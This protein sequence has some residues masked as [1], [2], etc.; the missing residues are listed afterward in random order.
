MWGRPVEFEKRRVR[1]VDAFWNCGALDS[2]EASGV[3]VKVPLR[4]MPLPWAG[5]VL[6]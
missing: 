1:E 3:G 6:R 4:R 5:R 2:F